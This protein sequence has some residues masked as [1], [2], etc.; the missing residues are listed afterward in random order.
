M[1]TDEMTELKN[2]RFLMNSPLISVAIIV[3]LNEKNLERRGLSRHRVAKLK[4]D[5]KWAK[6]E[7]I[8]ERKQKESVF[9]ASLCQICDEH[10]SRLETTIKD[11]KP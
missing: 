7:L 2:Y 3:A 1:N 4:R 10:L 8:F 11:Q 5:V 6:K 9:L